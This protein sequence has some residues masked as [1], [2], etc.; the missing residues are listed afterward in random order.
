MAIRND[1]VLVGAPGGNRGVVYLLARQTGKQIA[2]FHDNPHDESMGAGVA[3]ALAE[4]RIA[5][6]AI[7]DA[8]GPRLRSVIRSFGESS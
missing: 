7:R 4:R 2:T 3:V 1:R 5:V 8:C 6:G